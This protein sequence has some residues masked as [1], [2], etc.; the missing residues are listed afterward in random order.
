MTKKLENM[1][2]SNDIA[3][4][5]MGCI[6]PKSR[7]L[8]EY[9]HLLFNGIDAVENIPEDT[10]WK[11]EDYFDEDPSKPD[12]TYCKRGGFLPEIDFNPDDYESNQ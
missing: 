6:F 8:K 12:H 10:H 1:Q 5:G 3:I 11:I 7:N 4:V 9:W 2:N